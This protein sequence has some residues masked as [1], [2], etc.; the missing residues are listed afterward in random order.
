[1]AYK[2]FPKI[3]LSSHI[4]SVVAWVGCWRNMVYV[5]IFLEKEQIRYACP[6]F[7]KFP[8]LLPFYGLFIEPYVIVQG[9]TKLRK[10]TAISICAF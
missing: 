7:S 1:M 2:F 6:N 4:N 3:G 10:E 9:A 8:I 5:M